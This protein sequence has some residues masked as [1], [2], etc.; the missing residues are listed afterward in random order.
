MGVEGKGL[1]CLVSHYSSSCGVLSVQIPERKGTKHRYDAYG[2]AA[3]Q[4]QD[5]RPGP[6]G[7]MYT[8]QQRV[9]FAGAGGVVAEGKD[10]KLGSSML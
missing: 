3:E 5:R 8:R 7:P 6:L 2:A 4:P 10:N 9:H 1:L